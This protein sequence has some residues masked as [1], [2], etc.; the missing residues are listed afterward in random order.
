MA[1][2]LILL[3]RNLFFIGQRGRRFIEIAIGSSELL[4]LSLHIVILLFWSQ[5]EDSVPLWKLVMCS[6]KRL[7]FLNDWGWHVSFRFW[8][9]EF[10][11][12]LLLLI[13]T[14]YNVPRFEIILK[15]FEQS[16]G[17]LVLWRIW[18][19]KVRLALFFSPS[20]FPYILSLHGWV[21]VKL[22]LVWF[23]WAR[24]WNPHGVVF[25]EIVHLYIL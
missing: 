5:T 7:D 10:T 8:K 1:K 19:L 15:L 13:F 9:T 2:V 3:L 11:W 6:I 14:F 25:A 23:S 22:I 4:S 12:G 18:G 20:L 17:I 16:R 24:S 21:H